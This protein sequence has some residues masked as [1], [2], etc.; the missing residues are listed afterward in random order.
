VPLSKKKRFEVFKRDGF[1]CR[2]CGKRPPDTVLEVDHVVPKSGGGG[3]ET[4]NLVTSCFECNRGKGAS[5]LGRVLPQVDAMDLLAATRDLMER[6]L[7][8]EGTVKARK[9]VQKAEDKALEFILESWERETERSRHALD[10]KSLRSFLRKM[11]LDSILDAVRSTAQGR[12]ISSD[13][14]ASRYFYKACWNMIR[15][16]EGEA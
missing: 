10:V 8:M 16:A 11:P 12:G 1:V 6:K 4:E 13:W 7:T 5:S 3:D 9:S 15:E 14:R 2:Y